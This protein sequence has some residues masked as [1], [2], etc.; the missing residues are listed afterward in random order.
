M[1]PRGEFWPSVWRG[2]EGPRAPAPAF[3]CWPET[4]EG[5]PPTTLEEQGPCPRGAVEGDAPLPACFAESSL[6]E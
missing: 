2:S 6:A 1:E 5:S 3:T 4:L